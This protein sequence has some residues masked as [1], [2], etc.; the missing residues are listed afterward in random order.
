MQRDT[1]TVIYRT[2]GTVNFKWHKAFPV[3]TATEAEALRQSTERMGYKA[4]THR[5]SELNK[6]GLPETYE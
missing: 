4:L 5:T 1:F 6:I 3:E 2:G